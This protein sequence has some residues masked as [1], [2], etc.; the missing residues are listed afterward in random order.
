MS[1]PPYSP[2]LARTGLHLFLKLNLCPT[3]MKFKTDKKVI[4]EVDQY[5]DDLESDD[6]KT[7]IMALHHRWPKGIDVCDRKIVAVIVYV[8]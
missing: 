1:Q 5:F 4:V 2:D 3:G 6:Y 7:G 8:D